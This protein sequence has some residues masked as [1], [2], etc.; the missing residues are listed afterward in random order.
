MKKVTK[1]LFVYFLVFVIVEAIDL[2]FVPAENLNTCYGS[3]ACSCILKCVSYRKTT[4]YA[5]SLLGYCKKKLKCY[6]KM[7]KNIQ[8]GQCCYQ[9]ASLPKHKKKTEKKMKKL[10]Q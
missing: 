4:F 2:K 6:V 3:P 9:C 8:I 1:L 7:L 10:E 5:Q